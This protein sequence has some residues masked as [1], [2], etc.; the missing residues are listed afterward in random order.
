MLNLKS[1]LFI[2]LLFLSAGSGMSQKNSY[3][4]IPQPLH[5]KPAAGQFTFDRDTRLLPDENA[6]EPAAEAFFVLAERLK[7]AGGIDLKG[8]ATGKS[9]VIVCKLNRQLP[10]GE[11]YKLSIHP[12]RIVVEARE[13]AGFF[14]AAQTLRQLLPP[15]IES[16]TLQSNVKWTV[17]CCRID[18]TPRH[19]YR[20]MHL[21]VCRHFSPKEE[22]MHYIDQLALLKINTLHWHLTD[23][24]GWRIEIKKYPRLTEIGGFRNRTV[25]GHYGDQPRR[26]DDTRVGGFYTQEEIR[27]VVRYAQKRFV[28]ILPEIEMPGHAVAALTAYPQYSCSG[29]PFEV[30]GLWGVFNDVYCTREE[31]FGFLEGILEEVAGLFPYPYI[32]IG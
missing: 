19:A 30:E 20:G 12:N 32:H 23:D 21:D 17:P 11:S 13:P 22:V 2:L 31:T 18:D 24:Q 15:E 29:G 9:N 26:W 4:I 5:L 6:G 16:P 8:T 1:F 25:I 3:N 14:Y 27:E 7:A 10:Q 28:N